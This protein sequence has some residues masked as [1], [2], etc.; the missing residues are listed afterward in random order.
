VSVPRFFEFF[1]YLLFYYFIL[2]LNFF[3]KI[4]KLPRVNLSSCHLAVTVTRVSIMPGV[5]SLVSIWSLYFNLSQFSPNFYKNL[6]ILSLS[7][8][9]SNL[10]LYN[11]YTNIFIKFDIFIQI[12]IVIIY[13]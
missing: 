2:F 3:K 13:F 1:Y 6:A 5:I 7:K 4:K 8:F 11:C 12:D 10:I 9:K